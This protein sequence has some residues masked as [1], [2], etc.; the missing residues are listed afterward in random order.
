MNQKQNLSALEDQALERFER[1]HNLAIEG[2]TDGK[3]RGDRL[4]ALAVID[5][6]NLWSLF[7]R[8]FYISCFLSARKPDG[9]Y[10]ACSYVGSKTPDVAIKQAIL[11]NNPKFRARTW[12]MRDEPAWHDTSI[13]IRLATKFNFSNKAAK[14]PRR[15]NLNDRRDWRRRW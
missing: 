11:L 5:T 13:L 15:N 1:L 14:H 7:V 12:T 2:L 9:T 6:H 8:A 3:K 4:I 10:I